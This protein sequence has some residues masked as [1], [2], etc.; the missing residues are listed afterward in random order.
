MPQGHTTFAYA[1]TAAA[2]VPFQTHYGPF[3]AFGALTAGQIAVLGS[4]NLPAGY[5][6]VIGRTVRVT[7]K[8]AL[9]TLNTA[10]LPYITLGLNWVG[11]LTAGAP[12]AVCSLVPAAAGSTATAN[13]FFTCTLTTN[14]VGATAIGTV[15]TNGYELLTPAAGGALTGATGDTGT[16]AIASLGLFAQNTLNV[17]YTSTTNATAGEQLLDLHVETLQ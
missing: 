2:P 1:P 11:G 15:M 8:I 13:E 3:P 10:T 9:T 4:V 7:G 6:N 16:A 17:I 5:L 14:A 12:I